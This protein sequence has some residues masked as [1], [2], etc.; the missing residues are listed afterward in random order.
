MLWLPIMFSFDGEPASA[1]GILGGPGA[2]FD[3]STEASSPP[4]T[5][6][7][8]LNGDGKARPLTL[9]RAAATGL[10]DLLPGSVALIAAG[11]GDGGG[12]GGART[13]LDIGSMAF[14]CRMA[15]GFC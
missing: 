7:L 1:R 3:I 6:D 2:I 12:G 4:L 13:G 9:M 5:V 10:Q 15:E 14:D 8:V 11:A